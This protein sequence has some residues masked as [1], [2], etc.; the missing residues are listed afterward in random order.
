MTQWVVL[1][2]L[3]LMAW[4]AH[5]LDEQPFTR[6]DRITVQG[7]LE[8]Y[9]AIAANLPQQKLAD[10]LNQIDDELKSSLK[11]SVFSYING[12]VNY[13]CYYKDCEWSEYIHSGNSYNIR[14]FLE[15]YGRAGGVKDCYFVMINRDELVS[16][17]FQA[18]LYEK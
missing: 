7:V 11:V 13:N 12:R 2:L 5:S 6:E 8:R 15:Q 10:L 9:P 4:R 18:Y 14:R 16:L 3:G 17:W 1:L